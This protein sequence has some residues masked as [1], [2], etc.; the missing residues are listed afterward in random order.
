M[1]YQQNIHKL[2]IITSH[3]KSYSRLYLIRSTIITFWCQFFSGPVNITE[4]EKKNLLTQRT[5]QLN[6]D[7][8]QIL[9]FQSIRFMNIYFYSLQ[10]NTLYLVSFEF[11]W[12]HMDIIFSQIY[13]KV[14]VKS[15]LLFHLIWKDYIL[16]WDFD[17]KSWI[18]DYIAGF[19]H[20]KT[21]QNNFSFQ[22]FSV[23]IVIFCTE[24]KSC[25]VVFFHEWNEWKNPQFNFSSLKSQ[26]RM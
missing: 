24:K 22:N 21:P 19:T 5:I 4:F 2:H 17:Q 23:E 9:L 6:K 20:E 13:G 10:W 15:W 14:G 26:Y 3:F 11:F 18:V 1:L 12:L 16:H 25:F 8:T 7:Q